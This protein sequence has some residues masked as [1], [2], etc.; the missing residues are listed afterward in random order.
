MEGGVCS[1]AVFLFVSGVFLLI[2]K[3][4]LKVRQSPYMDH[5]EIRSGN[6]M[7]TRLVGI[8]PSNYRFAVYLISVYLSFEGGL[9]SYKHTKVYVFSTSS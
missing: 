7:A 8:S 3:Q 5:K 4:S 6:S 1:N 9:A 2:S